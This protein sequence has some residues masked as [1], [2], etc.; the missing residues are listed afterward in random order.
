MRSRGSPAAASLRA[1]N[2]VGVTKRSTQRLQVSR[3][4]WCAMVSAHTSVCAREPR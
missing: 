4:R 1:A 3:A 2:A